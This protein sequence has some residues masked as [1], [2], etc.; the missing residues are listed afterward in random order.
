VNVEELDAIAEAVEA[1][2]AEPADVP[3]P[4]PAPLSRPTTPGRWSRGHTTAVTPVAFGHVR[5]GE[6]R[7]ASRLQMSAALA[8]LDKAAPI[9]PPPVQ[10]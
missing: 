2:R 3:H 8:A 4:G 10:S 5:L 9:E 1:Q 6:Q 7:F